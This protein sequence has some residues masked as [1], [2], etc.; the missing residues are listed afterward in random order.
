M[1][2]PVILGAALSLVSCRQDAGPDATSSS[3]TPPPS[4]VWVV[5]QRDPG[6]NVPPAGRSL[7]DH[8]FTKERNGRKVYEVPFPFAILLDKIDRELEPAGGATP[9][10]RLLI[11]VNRSLQRN[12]A[13]PDFFTFPRAVVAVDTEWRDRLHGA[14]LFLK[15]RLF[16]GYQEKAGVIEVI[17]YNEA[18]GRFEFQVVTD[19]RAGG[20]PTVRYA[21]RAICTVCHQNHS[22][23]FSRPLWDETNANPAIADALNAQRRDF[24]GFP[25]HQGVDVATAFDEA[26]DRANEFAAHQLLW[27]EGCE[28]PASPGKSAACRADILRFLLQYRLSGARAV[29]VRAT[30]YREQWG[31]S[32]TQ[33]WRE[34][35]P[36][37]LMIPDPDVRNRNPL[38]FVQYAGGTARMRAVALD[39]REQP[40]LRSVFEPSL[41]RGPAAIWTAEPGSDGVNRVIAGLSQFLAD[42]DI[43]RLDDHLSRGMRGTAE[44]RYAASC[45]YTIRKRGATAERLLV[46][47]DPPERLQPDFAGGFAMDGVLYRNADASIAG[48]ITHLSFPEGDEISDLDVVGNAVPARHGEIAGR[49]TLTQKPSGLHARRLS[50][51]A[52][53]GLT[54]RIERAATRDTHPERTGAATVSVVQDF[55]TVHRAIDAVTADTLSGAT[56]ALARR[57]FRRA[58]VLKALFARLGLPAMEWCCID[59]DGMPPIVTDGNADDH[60][61]IDTAAASAELK[62]FQR[63]CGACHHEHE[64]F[65][66]N[67]LH[68]T[69]AQVKEQMDHC[70]QRILFRLEMWGLP[71]AE[72][73]EAPMPPVAGLVRLNVPPEHWPAHADLAKLKAYV[74]RSVNPEA[75]LPSREAWRSQDYDGLRECL[76]LPASSGNER[77]RRDERHPARGAS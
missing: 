48:T 4:P 41:P 26:T 74:A 27:Q 55:E 24:Y 77:D 3:A 5:D 76:P 63:Y 32:F 22:P 50:G 39:G 28:Q 62:L 69:P 58:S 8:L 33:R 64:P 53:T 13:K 49:L 36:Q 38:A 23:I 29:D 40:G 14:V 66:P 16:L 61:G 20:A 73:P 70:A 6:A 60:T 67:F 18:A 71:P 31:P 9:L 51:N 46:R 30:R 59:D 25:I 43:R 17:S 35:W 44:T 65:P 2:G 12:A 11:P 7:F 52:V 56:D 54:F 72:R 19:Y 42:A 68:G 75:R 57:P 45:R 47:C 15:D 21:N 37:G 10:K 1:V 34:K